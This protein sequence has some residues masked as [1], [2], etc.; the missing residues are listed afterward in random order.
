MGANVSTVS[1]DG[2]GTAL[3]KVLHTFDQ[4]NMKSADKVMQAATLNVSGAVIEET[5]VGDFDPEHMGI[6]KGGWVITRGT[7]SRTKYKRQMPDRTRKDISNLIS[8]KIVSTRV[9]HYLTN[10]VAYVNVVEYGGYKRSPKI[11][12]FNKVT[13]RY[14]IRSEGGFSKQAPRGMVRRNVGKWKKFVEIAANKI[15]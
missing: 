4:V 3:L 8:D 2:L 6:L 5:P 13:Q 14:E 9:T 7:P 11:G 15:L 12:T 1:P 10:N